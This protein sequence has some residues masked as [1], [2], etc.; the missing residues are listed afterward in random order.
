[1]LIKRFYDNKLAQA[2]YLVGCQATGEAV[3]ID[4]NRDADH[5]VDAAEEE[6]MR[7]TAVTETHIHADYASGTRELAKKTGATMYLSAEGGPGWEYEFAEE[8][9]ATLVRDGDSFEIGNIRFRILHTPGHTPEHIC[10]EVTDGAAS[11]EPM[12]IFTGDFIFVGD[13]GRP[14][15]LEKA[16]GV[17]G[18]MEASARQLYKSLGSVRE[19]PDYLQIWPGH[20][21]GSA[22]GKAL[23]AVPQTTLGYER[24]VNWAFACETEDDFVQ[25]V[26]R[27]QPEPPVYFAKMKTGNR[28]GWDVLGHLPVPDHLPADQLEGVIASG[29][30]VVD[31]RGRTAFQGGHIPGTISIPLNRS[32]TNW[33]GWLLSY[34]QPIYL[35]TDAGEEE[36]MGA[37]RDLA[38][39]GMDTVAGYFGPGA[40]S[41]WIESGKVLES[42]PSIGPADVVQRLDAGEVHLIDVRGTAEWKEGHIP[43]AHH[44]HLGMLTDHLD[45]CPTDKPIVV[46][47]GTGARSAIGQSL[48]LKHGY[49]DVINLE[50][51][52]LGWR[53]AGLPV[54]ND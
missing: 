48:L 3:V 4:P 36:A 31:L 19:M 46:S 21:A 45:E 37:A 47:C 7:I 14:D 32:F 29:A 22:C 11:D 49:K 1:M 44:C 42:A 17:A 16:A 2:S 40:F 33:A 5:Y 52:W 50:G 8:D 23:G 26:L 9:G 10:F 6:G 54:A 20:G 13:V 43:W 53:Q 27:D 39:I 28:D 25:S 18:T 24:V 41:A 38:F 12:G 34:D 30:P 35:L 15:L 51:G